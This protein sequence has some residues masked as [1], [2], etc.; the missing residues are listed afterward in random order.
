MLLGSAT[1]AQIGAF[2]AA[3]ALRRDVGEDATVLLQCRA[4][5]MSHAL[6]FASRAADSIVIDI[7]GTGGDGLDTFNAST[8]ASLV[9]A[10]LVG[11]G[12]KIL[13][14]K[15][16]NRSASGK[17]GAADFFEALGGS[18]TAESARASAASNFSFLFAPAFHPALAA[19]R[20]LRREIGVRT[21]FNLLGPLMSP[22]A[23]SHL[24]LG[25]A[26][27]SLG[28]VYASLLAS[29]PGVLSALVVCGAGGL[30]E[31]SPEG[32][33]EYWR[34]DG[35]RVSHHGTFSLADFGLSHPHSLASVASGPTAAAN[36]AI[37]REMIAGKSE[38]H[39]ARVDFVSVNAAAALWVAG[40]APSLAA[41]TKMAQD[42][43]RSGRVQQWMASNKL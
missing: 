19:V 31:V 4:L 11:E 1:H 26:S 30:D 15:H 5:M 41:G 35:G 42:A 23:P 7:V 9:V 20:A 33:T 39:S 8:A 40:M 22:A 18:L 28:A 27:T 13:I 17:C 21:V 16:G 12:Q 25:V 10:S 29:T 6:P 24:V 38:A 34:V 3:L 43:I 14:A 37:W 2:L 36:A 32:A